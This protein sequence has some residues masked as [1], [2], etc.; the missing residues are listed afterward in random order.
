M[1]VVVS[2]CPTVKI[3]YKNSTTTNKIFFK[4]DTI[5]TR[6]ASPYFIYVSQ[7]IIYLV[8]TLDSVL[9]RSILS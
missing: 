1:K 3:A 4:F 5:F 6:A 2:V 8:F 7:K 9:L